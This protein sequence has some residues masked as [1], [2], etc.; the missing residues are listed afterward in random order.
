VAS[1]TTTFDTAGDLQS[2]TLTGSTDGIEFVRYWIDL[3]LVLQDTATYGP[4]PCPGGGF[5]GCAFEDSVEIEV[6]GTPSP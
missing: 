3:P 2:P 6:Y 5:S 1:G 4:N